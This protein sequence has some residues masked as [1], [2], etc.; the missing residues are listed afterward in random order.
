MYHKQNNRFSYHSNIVGLPLSELPLPL[1][2]ILVKT[3]DLRHKGEYGWKKLGK[4]FGINKV[5]LE[6]LET[7]YQRSVESPTKE[8]LEILDKSHRA[9][10]GDLLN[11]LKGS[12]V[13]QPTI[14][15]LIC[16]K[17]QE[18]KYAQARK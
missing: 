18:I 15:Q 11:K 1:E 3:L 16:E 14:A 9:T 8:L 5:D 2:S 13:N 12:H 6:Y 7:A 17:W 4:A 10:V